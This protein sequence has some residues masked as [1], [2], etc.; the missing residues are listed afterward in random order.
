M[1]TLRR[2]SNPGS[3]PDA[4]A[5]HGLP[6]A[7]NETY[8]CILA[9]DPRHI[10]A[11]W[12]FSPGAFAT[13]A[14]LAGKNGDGFNGVLR[15]FMVDSA[16]H[17]RGFKVADFP[18]KE[19]EESRYIPVPQQGRS[20]RLECGFATGS[21]RFIVLCSSNEVL[22]PDTT[23]H[24]KPILPRSGATI[25]RKPVLPGPNTVQR[26]AGESGSHP[27]AVPVPGASTCDD[28]PEVPSSVSL[29]DAH[30]CRMGSSA[31]CIPSPVSGGLAG[32]R[33][34]LVW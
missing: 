25:H 28:G 19:G 10:F 8:L 18:F 24:M 4:P 23:I 30:L 31:Q 27:D 7:Y 22:T 20:Y 33:H 1:A 21:G 29:S 3:L 34:S 15:L 11:F 32:R 9:R 14:E 12:E 13:A 16:P 2:Q 6:A 26:T 5:K 17:D